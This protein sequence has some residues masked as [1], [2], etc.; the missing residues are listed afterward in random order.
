M[1]KMV[2][3]DELAKSIEVSKATVNYYTNI[4]LIEVKEIKRNK[5]LYD[6]EE[7]R[8]RVLKVREMMKMGYTIK[9]ILRELAL[10]G[11]ADWDKKKI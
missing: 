7:V 1:K 3:V 9:L 11:F 2:N 6:L 4:G 8:R 5:R 10:A